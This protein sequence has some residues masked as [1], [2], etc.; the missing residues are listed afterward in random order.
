MAEITFKGN[1][2]HTQYNLPSVGEK[3]PDFSLTTNGLKEVSLADYAGKT[4]VL[5]IN[6]SYDTGICQLTAKRFNAEASGLDNTVVLAIS[7]DLPFAQKRF[8]G[9][10]GLDNVEFLSMFR[11]RK[12][13]KD[14]GMLMT[15]GPLGGLLARAVVII[16]ANDVVTYTQ[17]VDEIVTE[18]D[19][20]AALAALKG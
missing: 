12:F 20:E 9:A 15:D 10:E 14:Y 13:A 17:L 19:Y 16:D 18:P 7:S 3:A 5:T 4:R 11:D 1:P 2:I 6:P 8:C